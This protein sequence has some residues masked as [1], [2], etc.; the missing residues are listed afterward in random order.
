MVEARDVEAEIARLATAIEAIRTQISTRFLGQDAVIEELLVAL[1]A[2]GHVLLEGAPGLGKT[3]LVR[4]LARALDLE[5]RRV[6][7]TPDLMPADILGT[8][9]L[10]EDEH[11]KRRFRF[12]KGPVFAHVLLADEINRATPRTQAALLEAMAE[13]QVTIFG[14]TRALEAPFFVVATQNPIEMEGTYPLPEAQLDR[15]LLKIEVDAPAF[16]ALVAIL[17]RTTGVETNAGEALLTRAALLSGRALVREVPASRD[18]LEYAARIVVATRPDD[19][20]ASDS[21]RRYVRYGSSPRGAQAL[22]L[23]SKARALLA[24]RLHVAQE[25]IDRLAASALRHRLILNYEADAASVRPTD[26]VR[27]VVERSRRR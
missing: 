4:T 19:P 14:E 17:A 16:D 20:S 5:F 12:E 11:G 18:M 9:I 2:D 23:A 13:R 3:M 25:D 7:C 10:D 15:F 24:G 27:E 26:L 22:I 8:R 21:V 6:Q 1:L